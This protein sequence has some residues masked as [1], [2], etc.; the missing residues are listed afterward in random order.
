MSVKVAVVIPCRNERE[1]ITDCIDAVFAAQ[2][3]GIELE[4]LVCDGMSD[5]GTREELLK[6]QEKFQHLLVVDNKA[7]T[8][9]QALNLGIKKTNAE[10]VVI[11]GAH[12]KVDAGF[13]VENLKG[14][15]EHPEAEC[16]GGLANNVS[17][18]EEARLI[19]LAM[20]SPF[21]VG[22][23]HF[24]T[25]TKEGFVDTVAFG[26][27]RKSLFDRIGLFDEDLVRN[28][29]D[30]FNFRIIKNGGKILLR[31]SVKYDY[32]VR[33][34]IPK[35]A[36]QYY[37]YG[38]WKVFVNRKH[39]TI[40]T[41]RQLA[42]LFFVLTLYCFWFS[43]IAFLSFYLMGNDVL[44]KGGA[45]VLFFSIVLLMMYKAANIFYSMKLSRDFYELTKIYRVFFALHYH[46]GKGYFFGLIRFVMLGR[47]PAKKTQEMS[48]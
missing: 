16:V 48:R 12:S 13:F 32:F 43:L 14:F 15:E 47:K 7:Q 45:V 40:T 1:F 6:L 4:V 23:A 22:N 2:L 34:S 27:Y 24:R 37:Q 33:G 38:Y 8:T 41:A 19:G 29:D 46:Y 44:L 26:M 30:E 25:A 18:N 31:S 42:P 11:L 10:Y 21:G 28:Q 3:S 36:K 20:S 39:K 35:L 17:L 9:P 5:D